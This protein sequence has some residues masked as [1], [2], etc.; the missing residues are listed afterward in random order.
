MHVSKAIQ[1]ILDPR[2]PKVMQRSIPTQRK[3]WQLQEM[4]DHRLVQCATRVVS[5]WYALPGASTQ[6]LDNALAF[7]HSRTDVEGDSIDNGMKTKLNI[8]NECVQSHSFRHLHLELGCSKAVSQQKS[9]TGLQV[10]HCVMYPF[11]E[12]ALPIC[13]FDLAAFGTS[14]P[15]AVADACP[16]SPDASLPAHIHSTMVA[17]QSQ[18]LHPIPRRSAP[19]WVRSS[20]FLSTVLFGS[21]Q[22]NKNKLSELIAMSACWLYIQGERIFSDAYVCLQPGSWEDAEPFLGRLNACSRNCAY[23][24]DICLSSL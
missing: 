4:L 22:H 2:L 14:V 16:V 11:A 20:F 10:L 17:A 13:C 8:E 12:T 9:N 6:P 23:R 7:A 1:H 21:L 3:Q 24:I 18:L 19:S 15:L 5:R